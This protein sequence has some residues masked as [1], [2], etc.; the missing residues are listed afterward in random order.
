L[1]HSVALQNA[2]PSTNNTK[3]P[4]KQNIAQQKIRTTK[5]CKNTALKSEQYRE[6]INLILI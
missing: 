5:N 2:Y 3:V 1:K 4:Q 6:R